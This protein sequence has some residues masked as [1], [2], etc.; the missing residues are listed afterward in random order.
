[1]KFM[2]YKTVSYINGEYVSEEKTTVSAMDLG[3][4]RGFGVFEMIKTYR[5]KPFHLKDH[6]D[7]LRKSTSSLNLNLDVTDV[8]IVKIIDRLL[9]VNRLREACIRIVVTG[10]PTFDYILPSGQHSLMMFTT[11]FLNYPS[12]FYKNGI[13]AITFEA[14]RF[15]PECKSLGYMS[16]VLG[17]QKAK[18]KNAQEAIYINRKKEVLEG[19][20]CNFFAIKGNTLIT[21]DEGILHG[22]TRQVLLELL[23]P[24]FDIEKRVIPLEELPS[25]EEAF[26]TST[27]KEVMPVVKIDDQVIGDGHVGIQTKK[28]MQLFEEY[29]KLP[30]W[31]LEKKLQEAVE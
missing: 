16:A 20:T 2:G 14:E 13:H 12:H 27:N 3:L 11:P 24:H 29:T 8:G 22:V 19:T 10:G 25:F 6:L 21:S 1:M 17:L 15:M 31:K 30:E 4:L 5:G 7:R 23:A 26:F 28:V 18:Q 9:K